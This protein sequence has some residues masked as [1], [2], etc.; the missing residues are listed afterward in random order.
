MHYLKC[1]SNHEIYYSTFCRDQNKK[2]NIFS[3]SFQGKRYS[4]AFHDVKYT[5]DLILLAFTMAKE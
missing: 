2:I 1:K 3:G 5:V 4:H